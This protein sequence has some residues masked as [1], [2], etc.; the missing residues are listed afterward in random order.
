MIKMK[1]AF[2]GLNNSNL[3]QTKAL[4]KYRTEMTLLTAEQIKQD[5]ILKSSIATDYSKK[6][7]TDART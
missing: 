6:V 7:A 2:A 1:A 4:S 5:A 3:L